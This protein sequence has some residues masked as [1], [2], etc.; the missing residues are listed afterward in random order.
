MD[1][2]VTLGAFLACVILAMAFLRSEWRHMVIDEKGI[3]FHRP[4][5][6]TKFIPW[7]DVRDWGVAHQMTRYGWVYYL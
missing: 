6:R 7:G 2:R 1:I 4:L 5:A 3:Y